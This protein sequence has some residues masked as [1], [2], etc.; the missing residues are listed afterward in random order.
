MPAIASGFQVRV[1]LRDLRRKM[2]ALGVR[3]ATNVVRRGLLA[4]AGLIRDDA[5]LRVPTRTG[6]LKKAI[7]AE[8]DRKGS[9]RER[10]V[11]NVKIAP[12]SFS[13]TPKGKA[14]AVSAKVQKARGKRTVRGEIYP[15]AYA[16]LVEYGTRAHHVGK[17]SKLSKGK[18]SGRVHPGTAPRPFLR[19]AYDS[20]SGEALKT[21]ERVIRA[22]LQKELV[23]LGQSTVRSATA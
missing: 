11:A 18:G 16:H 12:K 17:G 22:E 6:A 15:R 10:L 14:K 20:K 1:D 9:T 19:P 8:T 23:K 21:V 13:V 7:I 2:E 5:R 3:V 4:G